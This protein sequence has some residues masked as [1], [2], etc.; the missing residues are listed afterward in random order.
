MKIIED[1]I[2]EII[3]L[4]LSDKISFRTIQ[5]EYGLREKDVKRVMRKN[6]KP[7][8]YKNWRK[9]VRDFSDRWPKYK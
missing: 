9:R 4:A 8:S 6:L 2:S 3:E 7:R 5:N 1:N